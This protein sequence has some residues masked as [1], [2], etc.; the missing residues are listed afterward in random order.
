M[1]SVMG[2]RSFKAALILVSAILKTEGTVLHHQG[3]LIRKILWLASVLLLATSIWLGKSAALAAVLR[4]CVTFLVR[5]LLLITRSGLFK[6]NCDSTNT[7]GR[8]L[9]Q[10]TRSSLRL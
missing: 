6:T 8:S 4:L 10:S 5:G 7:Q 9:A 3:L 2:C 1:I